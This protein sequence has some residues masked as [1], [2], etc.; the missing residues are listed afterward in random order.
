[1]AKPVVVDIPHHLGSREARRRIEGGLG[2]IRDQIAANVA[3]LDEHWEGDR[4]IFDAQAM[5]Q[6]ITG[7]I[8]CLEESVR[9]EVDLPWYLAAFAEKLQGR[10]KKEGA[11]L[12]E[13]QPEKTK[14]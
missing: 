10:L 7:R 13:H 11:A 8:D 4:L 1:M 3:K 2:R 5:G 12:L 6:R 9:V 14:A